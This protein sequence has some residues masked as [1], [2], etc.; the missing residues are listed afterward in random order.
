MTTTIDQP[1]RSDSDDRKVGRELS[2]GVFR[3]ATLFVNAYLI[4][5]PGQS[6]LLVDTGLPGFAGLVKRRAEALF[7]GPP[8]AILLTHGHFDHSGNAEELAAFWGVPIFAHPMEM[9]F[10]TGRSDYPPVDPTVGGAL[11]FLARSFPHHG[12]DLRRHVQPLPED[13]SVPGLPGWRWVHTPGHTA[14][15][16]S[17]F[18]ESDRTLLAGDALATLDQDS[19]VAMLT[20]RRE[21]SVPPAPL[22]TDWRA[23]RASVETLAGLKPHAVAA[24]PGRPAR[25]PHVAADLDRF[26][27]I[28]SP[29]KRGRYVARP[30]RS[31]EYGIFEIPPPVEDPLPKQIL[32]AGLAT[33]ALVALVQGLRSRRERT[34]WERP[35]YHP[36]G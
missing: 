21:F 33:G 26:A 27:R 2:P 10:L 18:R 20:Q 15:H 11:G 3:L 35:R 23:A 9:P 6:G 12:I 34:R 32:L 13:G 8:R 16:V 14:G 22:T 30:A 28:F 5:E 36:R 29:P 7:G 19:P 31:N 1:I 25:G 4:H 17:L 24:G